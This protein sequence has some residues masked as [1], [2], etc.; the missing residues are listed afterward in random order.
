V[1]SEPQVAAVFEPQQAQT[2]GRKSGPG[3]AKR[4][5]FALVDSR[6][7]LL[8]LLNL[9]LILFMYLKTGSGFLSIENM[10]SVALDSATYGILTV[11]MMLLMIAGVFDLSIGGVLTMTGIV[12][13]IAA[14]DGVPIVLAWGVGIGAGALCG[15]ANGLIVTRMRLNALIVT[16]ATAG[17]YT[18]MAQLF[19][20]TGVTEI[21]SGYETL[22]QT[23]WLGFQVPVWIWLG[24][25]AVFTFLAHRQRWFRYLF[26]IGGNERAA[27]L[28]GIDTNRVRFVAFILM[29][30]L[31][32]LAGVL[33]ASRL[34]AAVVSAGDNVPLNVITAAVLGGAALTGGSG[35]IPGSALAIFFLS[36]IQDAMIVVNVDVF[37]QQIVV[38]VVLIAAVS[39]EYIQH[40]RSS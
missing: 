25:A 19:S 40:R 36:L 5:A 31:A 34:D 22:G 10:S 4:G 26:F 11:G 12:S 21:K 20:G 35:S 1:S 3:L 37:W 15:L 33:V 8:I 30:A 17:I 13:A 39:T 27:R 32:G 16:L 18:G 29:G 6:P 28:S 23:Q 2:P 9:L 38:G 7:L 24:L 14:N